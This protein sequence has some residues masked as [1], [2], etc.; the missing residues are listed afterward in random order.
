MSMVRIEESLH[1]ALRDAADRE[2]R[3]IGK[4]IEDAF[5]VYQRDQFWSGV[6]EDYA[7]LRANPIAF[8]GWRQE[9]SSFE[10]GSLDG[11]RDEPPYYSPQ[12]EA[13]IRASRD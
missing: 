11:L 2:G 8:A 3:S 4:V 5:A 12:E 13:E 6:R 10:S 1:A 7:R 9:V